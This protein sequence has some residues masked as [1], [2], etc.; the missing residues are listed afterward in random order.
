MSVIT[1]QIAAVEFQANSKQANAAIDSMRVEAEKCDKKIAMLQERYE[2]GF[3]TVSINGATVDIQKHIKE[4]QRLSKTYTDAANSQVKGVKAFD[5]LWKKSRLGR[6]EELTAQ[7]IK[8]GVNGGKRIYDRLKLGD[9]ED[10][11]IAA[12]MKDTFDQAQIVLDKLQ[13]RTNEIIRTIGDGGNVADEVLQR[14]KKYLQDMMDLSEKFGPEWQEYNRQL[15]AINDGIEKQTA[16]EKRLRGELVDVNDA[17]KEAAKLDKDEADA[18]KQR[19]NAQEDIIKAANEEIEKHKELRRQHSDTAQS[20]SEEIASQERQI[21]DQ[22]KVVQGIENEIKARKESDKAIKQQANSYAS[23]AKTR[24]RQID[25]SVKKEDGFRKT[26]SEAA[27]K[28]VELNEQLNKL[29][30]SSAPKDHTVLDQLKKDAEDAGIKVSEAQKKLDAILEKDSYDYTKNNPHV[31]QIDEEIEQI[32]KL[33]AVSDKYRK[34]FAKMSDTSFEKGYLGSKD[35]RKD[36]YKA[37]DYLKRA[38]ED[39]FKA[40]VA[41]MNPDDKEIQEAAQRVAKGIV[42]NAQE[43]MRRAIYN[44]IKNGTLTSD[45]MRE[46][47]EGYRN[48]AQQAGREAVN[49]KDDPEYNAYKYIIAQMEKYLEVAKQVEAERAKMKGSEPFI[50]ATQSDVMNGVFGKGFKDQID[51]RVFKRLDEEKEGDKQRERD[52]AKAIVELNQAKQD[53][54]DILSKLADEQKKYDETTTQS[55]DIEAKRKKLIGELTTQQNKQKKAEEDLANQQKETA[56]LQEEKNTADANAKQKQDELTKVQDEANNRLTTAKRTLEDMNRKRGESVDK[57]HAEQD[58]IKQEDKVID[59]QSAKVHNAQVEQAKNR[60]L[61]IDSIEKSI[62]L[63]R[64]QNRVIGDETNPE[65]VENEKLIGRLNQRLTEMKQHALELQRMSVAPKQY[66]N[67]SDVLGGDLGKQSEANIR[68]AITNAKELIQVYGTGSKRA[69]DLSVEIVNAEEYLKTVGVEA[70]RSARQQADAAKQADDKLKLMQGRMA[71][72]RTLTQSALTETQKFW[73]AQLEG[74]T[75]GSKAYKEAERNLKSISAELERNNKQQ[76]R[77]SANRLGR[78]DLSTLSEK[79]LQAAVAAAKQLAQSMQPASL[80]YKVLIGDI[81]RGEEALKKFGLQGQQSMQ[82]MTDRMKSLGKLSDSALEETRKFWEEQMAGADRGSKAYQTAEANLDKI[83]KKQQ[84]LALAQNKVSADSLLTASTSKQGFSGMSENELRKDINAAREYQK[85]LAADSDEYKNLSVAIVKADEYIK[86]YGVDAEKAKMKE[87]ELKASMRDRVSTLQKLQQAS[88]SGL[89]EAQKYWQTQMDGAEKGTKD[90][91]EAEAAL[92]KVNDQMSVRANAKTQ[93]VLGT[94]DKYGDAEVRDAVKAMEQLRDSQAHGSVEWDKYNSLVEKGRKYL[95][96]WANTDAVDKY[97]QKMQNLATISDAA[98]ADM[99]KF[100]ETTIA[101]TEQGSADLQK[102]EDYLK[103]VVAVENDRRDYKNTNDVELL[104]NNDLSKFSESEIRRAIEAGKQLIQTYETGSQDAKDLAKNIVNAEKHLE[105]Y[106]ISAEKSA[107]READAVKKAADERAQRDQLM[108]EQL[109]QGTSLSESALKAQESYWQRLIDDPKTAS[110]SLQQYQA[111][112]LKVD[113]IQKQMVADNGSNALKFFQGDTSDASAEQIKEQADALKKWRDT[114]PAQ[115]EADTIQQIDTILGQLGQSAKEAAGQVMSLQKAL[116][117]GQDATTPGNFKGTAEQ[118]KAAKKTLEDTL[119]VTDKYSDRYN[120]IRD[121]LQGIALEEQRVGERSAKVN[122]ILDHPKGK[123]FIELKLAVEE[124]RKALNGMD[125]STKDNQQAF[126]DLAKKVKECDLEMKNLA[127]ESKG[128]ANAFE[129][130]WQR[131]KTY[132]TFYVSAAA[133]LQKLGSTVDDMMNLSDK[134]GEVRKTTGFT[135]DQVNRLSNN[136]AKLDVRTPIDQLMELAST[137]GTLGLKSEEDVEGFT[138]AANKM[139]IALPELGEDA[140]QQLMRVAMATGEVDK[141]RKQMQDGTIQGSSA[142]AVAMEKIASTIDRLRASSAATAPEITDFVKRVGAVGSQ[143]GISVD[144][145][146]ALG[147]T[148]SS[149]GMGVEMAATALSRMIPAIKNNAFNVAQAIGVT[150]D[151][152][153]ELFDTGRGMEAILLIFQRMHDQNLDPDSIEKLL[154]TGGMQEVMKELNQQG[155]RAGIVFAGLSQN[156]DQLRESLGVAKE[157]YEEN[158]AIEQEFNRMNDTTA[159]KWARLKNQIEEFFVTAGNSNTVGTLIDWLR[160]LVDFLTG[161]VG[162]ALRIVSGLVKVIIVYIS[163]LKMNLGKALFMEAA[164]GLG[165]LTGMFKDFAVQTRDAIKYS[166]LLKRAK[167]EETAATIRATMAQKDLNKSLVANVWTAVAAAVIALGFVIYDYIDS[168]QEEGR[169]AAKFQAQLDQEAMKVDKLTDSI[170]QARAKVDEANKGVENAR[171][172]LDAAKK[173]TDGSTESSKRLKK[174]EENLLIAEENKRNAMAEQK[175]LIE[176]FNTQYSKYLGFMLSEVSSNYELANARQLV[177]DKLRE[178]LT[179]KREEAA[180]Q[181]VETKYGGDRDDAYGDL[182]NAVKGTYGKG[183]SKLDPTTVAKVMNGIAKAAN[184]AKDSWD[185]QRQIGKIFKGNGVR[186]YNKA[187]QKAIKYFDEVQNVKTETNKVEQQFTAEKTVDRNTSQGTL[188]N[189]TNAAFRNYNTLLKRYKSSKGDARKDAAAAVLSEMDTINEIR[190]NAP[191]Y[192]DMSNPAEAK[193]YR[194]FYRT[195]NAW[196]GYSRKEL[197]KAAGNRYHPRQTVTSTKDGYSGGEGFETSNTYTANPDANNPWGQHPDASSTNWEQFN[198]KELVE[199]RKQMNE[200]V[201]A[202]QDDSDVKTV[203][204][205]DPALQKAFPNGKGANMRTVNAWY[206][207]QRLAIQKELYDRNLTPTGNWNTPAKQK[208]GTSKALSLV[209]DNINSYLEELDAYYTKRKSDI[210]ESQGNGEIDEAE[211]RR[212]TLLNEQQW[213]KDRGN[214]QKMYSKDRDKVA[215]EDSERVYNILEDQTGDSI[216]YIKADMG[217]VFNYIEEVGKKKSVAAMEHIYS[218]LKLDYEKSFQKS[219]HAIAQEMQAI[220]DIIAK[221]RPFDGIVTNLQNNLETMGILQKDFE[222]RRQKLLNEGIQKGSQE[223]DALD[224]QQAEETPKRLSFLIGE[225]KNAYST[226]ADDILKRAS[227]SGLSSWVDAIKGDPDMKR[228]LMAELRSVFDDIQEAIKKEAGLIKKEA[229]NLWNNILIPKGKDSKETINMK[230]AFDAA[231]G[232]LGIEEGQ[233]SRANSLINAGPL[234]ERVADQLAIK[235]MQLQIALQEKYYATMRK[236]GD[237]KVEMLKADAKQLELEAESLSGAE[238]EAKIKEANKKREDA[239][240]TQQALNLSNTEEQSDMLKMEDEL[241]AK[242]D[243]T[244]NKIYTHLREWSELF[245]SSLTSMFE[246][247]NTGLGDYYDNLAKMRLTGEGAGGGTYVV[248]DNSGTEK[249]SAHYETL[250]GED[251][252]KRQLQIEQQNATADALHKVMDDINKKIND[253]I[254]DWMNSQL[255][256]QAVNANTNAVMANTKALYETAGGNGSDGSGDSVGGTAAK[257]AGKVAGTLLDKGIVDIGNGEDGDEETS[258]ARAARK[259]RGLPVD[260]DAYNNTGASS[261]DGQQTSP[262]LPGMEGNYYGIPW[263][264]DGGD[265]ATPPAADTVGGIGSAIANGVFQG[266]YGGTLDEVHIV[267]NRKKQ[268]QQILDDNANMTQTLIDNQNKVNNAVKT[269]NKKNTE[270]TQASFAKMAQACNLYGIAY[271]AMSNDNLSSTQKFLTI[272]LQGVGQ[273]AIA[274]LTTNMLQTDAQSKIELPGILGKAASQLGPI[275]GPIAFAAMTALLG[276][277]MAVATSKTAKSKSQISQV[278]GAGA[279][280]GRL[281]TGMLTYAEGNVNEFTDPDTL[282]PGKSYN[283]DAADGRTYRAKYTGKNPTTHI[284]NGPEFHLAGERGKEAIIDA[285]TT[286]LLQ[287]DDTGIWKSIQTLYNG[288]SLQSVR[289]STKGMRAFATG[290]LDDFDDALAESGV[291][292]DAA[293]NG[294]TLSPDAAAAMQQ[295]LDRNNELLQRALDEGIHAK[296]DVYG[297][298][299]LID[300]Y[301]TGK[302]TVNRHGE[303]Y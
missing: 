94:P 147:S 187:F 80:E 291:G 215:K 222:E 93:R 10:R 41:D 33:I 53:Q 109:K 8:A 34:Q 113:M 169:E 250:D 6:I 105:Q 170:G 179:L 294:T 261:S 159:A 54:K 145:V 223:Y 239:D 174:A 125:R 266:L 201:K 11:R 177:N 25:T 12:A 90:F 110:A 277:L 50:K 210:E 202:I 167:D 302:K 98:L 191:S 5:E 197:M 100:W 69:R 37:E 188:K 228:N 207:K 141:I 60:Q 27:A 49:L 30:G 290:N 282:T 92:Q 288:G 274:M 285:H 84:E 42:Q 206:N 14:E 190:N 253:E 161:N 265:G 193:A 183:R 175:R 40:S 263:Q 166:I 139:M 205:E 246:A 292:E 1:K 168:L 148:V 87:A 78:R 135:A 272:A 218:G 289:R 198:G 149:M 73:Q 48:L 255:Q 108:Q 71:N 45:R 83:V 81:N 208:K 114:L 126:D 242:I 102:Y 47:L 26:A 237:A 295:S 257:V 303:R 70:A 300:S 182:Y 251:A 36:V 132:V 154:G 244:D 85:S 152:I 232:R 235:Q 96:D 116:Q 241:Q 52:A 143:A 59:E 88:T 77:D 214:L 226:T 233:T 173:S 298:G 68:S 172:A 89:A 142:T 128:T 39:R 76:L 227:D 178:T 150:P 115:T 236:I 17:K 249:A 64:Q 245:S 219:N 268:N 212:R 56:R 72:L 101:N 199:R 22:Q 57:I 243:E 211:A 121:A 151:T 61:S 122:E 221:E 271:Q 269:G 131:L 220:A 106:G 280:A 247:S 19:Y 62:E 107:Q 79:E 133:A 32:E 95:E 155:A 230:Q 7:Q 270:N 127:G 189:Q 137:A 200:Y 134:M 258:N 29:G 35:E 118:L 130:A 160:Y 117:I 224:Q 2:K 275:A 43:N 58:A 21:R 196:H 240:M 124:G 140:A 192:Y 203:L 217:Q 51:D 279:S 301:D 55:A 103:K 136:L 4:L 75:K 74:S 231:I 104:N 213:Y 264:T 267:A 254:T 112:L 216:D 259:R 184:A 194:T 157:A 65:W 296:F 287:M 299:G 256:N 158:T 181:R 111:N 28:I 153:R 164:S 162:P 13:A 23:T 3:K 119:A 229:Q 204:S 44:E 293:N 165:K 273:M 156:V 276:G 97:E 20:I 248:I 283:V 234:S 176:E 186:L 185:F 18:A 225:A 238:K 16:A 180:I 24:Q 262:F 91:L 66:K 146:A 260:E 15:Q 171:K 163:V 86:L 31:K 278:T 38:Y 67:I 286:R 120:Q 63:L 9:E 46:S 123:S 144:Q 82:I 284:T 129:K 99:R 195:V 297:K 252:L 138:E 209:R 281:T